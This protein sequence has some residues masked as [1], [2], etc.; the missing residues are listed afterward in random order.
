M[1][2]ERVSVDSLQTDPV[3]AR[4][5]NVTVIAAS[6]RE[7]GQHRP[8]VVQ[9]SSNRIIAGNH[10][11]EAARALGWDE[12]DVF[13]VDDDD[14]QAVRRA[15]ADN[16][17][18]DQAGW[19]DQV[20]KD[21]MDSVGTDIPGIDDKMLERLAKLDADDDDEPDPLYPIVP[22][23]GEGYSYA[24]IIAT[25]VVDVAW[26]ESSLE[27]GK[28]KSYKSDAVGKCRV[29]TVD[30]FRELLPGMQSYVGE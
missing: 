29:L 6:L 16:A 15:I 3:N 30:Q 8:L 9:R 26:L 11:F 24:V 19:D 20:L 14:T 17:T 12:I 23:A 25:N 4:K 1:V 18:N 5:G 10:T 21:L 13:F 22:R 28:A 2:V 7:F 27:V